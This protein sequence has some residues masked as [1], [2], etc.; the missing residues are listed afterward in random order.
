MLTPSN[1]PKEIYRSGARTNVEKDYNQTS[2]LIYEEDK[3]EKEKS[4]NHYELWW[5]KVEVLG[6]T[7]GVMWNSPASTLVTNGRSGKCLGNQSLFVLI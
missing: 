1:E 6:Q 2:A 7:N 3:Q 5:I 4:I